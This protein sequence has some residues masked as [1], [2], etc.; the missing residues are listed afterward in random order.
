MYKLNMA[1]RLMQ[2]LTLGAVLLEFRPYS[3]E[4]HATSFL[5][6]CEVI[7]VVHSE[8]VRCCSTKEELMFALSCSHDHN[9]VTMK[10]RMQEFMMTTVMHRVQSRKSC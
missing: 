7:A 4:C 1:V 8:V 2:S 5:P 9:Q 10:T 6:L 3:T